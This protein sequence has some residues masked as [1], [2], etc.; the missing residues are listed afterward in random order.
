VQNPV[1]AA[2]ERLALSKAAFARQR[3]LPYDPVVKAEGGYTATLQ[4][5]V[6]AALDG[7]VEPEVACR[8]YAAWLD[9]LKVAEVV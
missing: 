9:S 5:R 1:T 3:G 8:E 7:L 4:P 6:I 2:R